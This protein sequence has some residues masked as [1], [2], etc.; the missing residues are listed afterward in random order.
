M[1]CFS[2][3]SEPWGSDFDYFVKFHS[4]MPFDAFNG[5]LVEQCLI[6]VAGI[7]LVTHPL[8]QV[9]R[10][11]KLPKRCKLVITGLTGDRH[12]SDRCRPQWSYWRVTRHLC[13]GDPVRLCMLQGDPTPMAGWPGVDPI[14]KKKGDLA[15]KMSHPILQGKPN[16]SHMC[17]RIN[18]T[19]MIDKTRVIPLQ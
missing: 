9:K 11:A 16:A 3:K 10:K 8:V 15:S 17:T 14:F 2:C 18:Y 7:K 4:L 6:Y 13:P 5:S 19:H 1:W 12:R